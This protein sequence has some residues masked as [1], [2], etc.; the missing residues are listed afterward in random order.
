MNEV[1]DLSYEDVVDEKFTV[2]LKKSH[3]TWKQ[4]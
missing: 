3:E 4:T 1:F 2:E